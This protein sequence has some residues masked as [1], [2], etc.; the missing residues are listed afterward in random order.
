MA[1]NSIVGGNIIV[2]VCTYVCMCTYGNNNVIYYT[3]Q[4]ML[5]VRMYVH[6]Y[7][8]IFVYSMCICIL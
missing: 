4:Y 7:V 2:A 5:H 3:M 8:C 6:I 1:R